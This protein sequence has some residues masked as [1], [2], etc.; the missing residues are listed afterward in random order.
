MPFPSYRIHLLRS[1]SAIFVVAVALNYVWELGQAP[2]FEGHESWEN[3][4]W[5]C[6]VASLGDGLI[7][8]TMYAIGWI[9]FGRRDWFMRVGPREYAVMLA[10]GLV[11]AIAIEWIAIHLLERW[12]YGPAMPLL[13]GLDLGL[14]PL[15]QMLI[16]PPIIFYIAK[17][18]LI[19]VNKTHS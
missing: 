15:L 2:L 3:M 4:W 7:L 19:A 16:L 14:V 18:W 9:V 6:F 12:E 5:H 13:P 1:L 11:V 8:W 17:K 10:S